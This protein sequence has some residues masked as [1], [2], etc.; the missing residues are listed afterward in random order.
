MTLERQIAAINN[1]KNSRQAGMQAG[2]QTDK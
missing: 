2:R 1:N